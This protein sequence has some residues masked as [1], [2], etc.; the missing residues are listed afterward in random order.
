MIKRILFQKTLKINFF[1]EELSSLVTKLTV[2]IQSYLAFILLRKT[3]YK[4]CL[5]LV[6]VV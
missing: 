3:L 2:V 6:Y 4:D 5:S 1:I